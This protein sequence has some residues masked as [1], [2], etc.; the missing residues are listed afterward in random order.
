MHN[1]DCAFFNKDIDR[2]Q[3][4]RIFTV[5]VRDEAD[6][7]WNIIIHIYDKRVTAKKNESGKKF[8]YSSDKSG[9]PVKLFSVL[10]NYHLGGRQ[11]QPPVNKIIAGFDAK[12]VDRISAGL[13]ELNWKEIQHL[14]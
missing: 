14:L 6:F 7:L 13:L 2:V 3:Q 4:K 9:N 12:E 10:Y 1:Y 8:S 11:C 5:A